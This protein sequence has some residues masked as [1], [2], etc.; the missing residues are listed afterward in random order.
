MPISSKKKTKKAGNM[1]FFSWYD[2]HI[3]RP[4][5]FFGEWSKPKKRINIYELL[6]RP[7]RKGGII[8]GDYPWTRPRRPCLDAWVRKHR[9]LK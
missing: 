8:F 7:K 6:K 5:P 3:N 1:P 2:P 4:P 9:K